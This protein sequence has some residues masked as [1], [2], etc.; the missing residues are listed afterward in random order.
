M[1]FFILLSSSTGIF[2]MIAVDLSTARRW[3]AGLRKV[4]A[5][6]FTVLTYDDSISY[7]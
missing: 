5:E 3:G 4:H 1:R 6:S 7:K 2:G